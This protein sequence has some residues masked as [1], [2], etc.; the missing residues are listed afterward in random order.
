MS[1]KS[2]RSAR[3]ASKPV[4]RKTRKVA[5]KQVKVA[6]PRK[7]GPAFVG[8]ARGK[9]G[10]PIR[11]TSGMFTLAALLSKGATMEALEK[12]NKKQKSDSL[13]PQHLQHLRYRGYAITSRETRKGTV[14]GISPKVNVA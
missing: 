4:A 2:K 8:P 3:K 14:Y 12:A 1:V 7:S 11:D 5:R 10:R 13:V 9:R 6:H